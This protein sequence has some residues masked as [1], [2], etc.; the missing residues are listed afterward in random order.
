MLLF[1]LLLFLYYNNDGKYV[2]DLCKYYCNG[3]DM[4]VQLKG[5]NTITIRRNTFN[6]CVKYFNNTL[7]AV[8]DCCYYC[9]DH[10]CV[11]I[12]IFSTIIIIIIIIMITIIIVNIVMIIIVHL[13]STYY[14]FSTIIIIIIIIIII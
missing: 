4:Q 14:Y 10:Y 2:N 3:Y 5:V 8:S 12:T 6:A 1:V 13:L 11:F 7:F 9:Y